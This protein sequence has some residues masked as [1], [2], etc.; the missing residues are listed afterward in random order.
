MFMHRQY[1]LQSEANTQ[2]SA[3][4]NYLSGL[5]NLSVIVNSSF[6]VY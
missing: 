1:R 6:Y 3:I 5:F 2:F 4:L